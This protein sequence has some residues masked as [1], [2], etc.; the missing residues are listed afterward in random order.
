[1]QEGKITAWILLF[2]AGY[3]PLL[4]SY[5][6]YFDVNLPET[7][8]YLANKGITLHVNGSINLKRPDE[9]SQKK[10]VIIFRRLLYY[11]IR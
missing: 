9:V 3:L 7:V 8:T 5:W 11:L 10:N 4:L 1:M 6:F 2:G